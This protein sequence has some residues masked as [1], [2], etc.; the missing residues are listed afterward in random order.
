MSRK[1]KGINAERE[2][3]HLFWANNWAAIRVAGSGSIKYPCPDVLAGNSRRKVAVECKSTKGEYQY[4]QKDEVEALKS[5]S[6]RFGAEPWIGV[7]FDNDSWYFVS[8]DDLAK[9]NKNFVVSRTHAK[10][11]GLNF[12]EM[13]GNI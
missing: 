8:L 3:I 12:N 11:K 7:R 10:Q 5:F 13:I 4:L 6:N 9:T 2:L 1:S